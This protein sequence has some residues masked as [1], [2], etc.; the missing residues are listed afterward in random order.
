M[1]TGDLGG[2]P[3]RAA[4]VTGGAGAGIGHGITTALAAAGWSVLIVDRDQAAAEALAQRTG[5]KALALDITADGAPDQAM[6]EALRHFGRLDGLVNN[7]G[8]GLAKPIEETTDADLARLFS[9]DFLAAFRFTRVALPELRK[10]R[11]AIVNIG[12]IHA[13]RAHPTYALYAS[14][15]AALEAFTRGAALENGPFG[16]RANIIHPGYVESPQNHALVNQFTGGKAEEWLGRYLNTKQAIPAPVTAAQVGALALFLL[17]RD[18]AT[19]T[20]Q[21]IA[22]DAGSSIMLYEREP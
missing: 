7:A 14:A 21:A 13:L 18:A 12:S 4:I 8:V 9:V 11:G 19:L 10:S 5:G 15:K 1:T 17:G 2:Y 3:A 22:L 20:G 6:A 16:V